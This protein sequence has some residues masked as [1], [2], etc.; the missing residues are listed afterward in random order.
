MRPA[1]N[2]FWVLGL[3]LIL[4]FAVLLISWDHMIPG[5]FLVGAYVALD[6]WFT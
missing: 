5:G 3:A 6:R 1:P 4:A 2:F